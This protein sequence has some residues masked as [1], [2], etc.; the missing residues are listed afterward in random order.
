VTC[1]GGRVDEASVDDHIFDVARN[2]GFGRPKKLDHPRRVGI[3][4][5]RRFASR[6]TTRSRERADRS[7]KPKSCTQPSGLSGNL[8]RAYGCGERGGHTQAFGDPWSATT[9][10]QG[11]SNV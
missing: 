2:R 9:N 5:Y 4:R 8:G 11:S 7:W 6:Q 10:S 3:S 1:S